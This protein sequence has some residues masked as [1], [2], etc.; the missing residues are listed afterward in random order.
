MTA[1]ISACTLKI[2]IKIGGF[3][4][5]I[6]ILKMEENMQHFW[7][8]AFYFKKGKNATEMQKDKKICAVYGADA[9]TDCMY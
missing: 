3:C 6:L 8:Y 1:V 9:V 7:C 5:T 2:F 4:A